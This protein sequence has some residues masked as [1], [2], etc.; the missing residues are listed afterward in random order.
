MS[1]IFVYL[2]LF[3]CAAIPIKKVYLFLA[4]P[5]KR[6]LKNTNPSV[7][8]AKNIIIFICTKC[9]ESIMGYGLCLFAYTYFFYNNEIFFIIA[10]LIIFSSFCWPVFD[11]FKVNS[12]IFFFLLGM[13]AVFNFHFIWLFPL[14]IALVILTV[15]SY[16][17]AYSIS[18][19]LL[20]LSSTFLTVPNIFLIINVMFFLVTI[21][22][23]ISPILNCISNAPISLKQVFNNRKIY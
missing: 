15:N 19:S 5:D 22:V 2:T 8:Q 13:Y 1:Q 16:E 6:S 21:F 17:I 23:F 10:A 18:I 3:I 20:L 7:N 14:T 4:P 9:T 12:N 11:K